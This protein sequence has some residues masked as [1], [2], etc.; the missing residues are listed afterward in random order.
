MKRVV[1]VLI[2]RGSRPSHGAKVMLCAAATYLAMYG[3]F[4][5]QTQRRGL[6]QLQ[7]ERKV[8]VSGPEQEDAPAK[9]LLLVSSIIKAS[10]PNHPD[11][12]RLARLI[13]IE[14]RNAGVD[15]LFVTAVVKA[16]SMFKSRAI[17]NKGARGLMQLMPKTGQYVSALADNSKRGKIDL[18][19]PATNLRLGIAYLKYLERRFAGD[20]HR[21]LIAYNWGPT[22]LTKALKAK[23]TLPEQSVQYAHKVL[24]HQDQWK[25]SLEMPAVS[26]ATAIG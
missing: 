26:D 3:A 17:S 23:R 15:P 1:A 21:A 6:K 18:H 24:S 5:L 9:E 8:A 25:T 19:D 20:K 4:S 11:T 13:I 7:Q 16:E 22:N 2:S 12:E 10:L 14:S